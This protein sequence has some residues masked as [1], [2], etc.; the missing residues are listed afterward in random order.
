MVSTHLKNRLVNL[1]HLPQKI[2]GKKMAKVAQLGFTV[3]SATFFWPKRLP[4]IQWEPGTLWKKTN[5]LLSGSTGVEVTP[6]PQG[7]E[8]TRGGSRFKPLRPKAKDGCGV[9]L[10]NRGVFLILKKRT[11]TSLVFYPGI[12]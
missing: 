9:F 6:C 1:D 2:G 4:W 10:E 5:Q 7:V 3:S 11:A 8:W 12:V